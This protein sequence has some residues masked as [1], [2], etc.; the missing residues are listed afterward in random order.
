MNG[1]FVPKNK[2]ERG[3]LGFSSWLNL[4]GGR[5]GVVGAV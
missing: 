1:F 5:M 3:C 2:V 4:E